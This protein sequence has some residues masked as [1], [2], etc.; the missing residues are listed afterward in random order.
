MAFY[1]IERDGYD[2]LFL[3]LLPRDVLRRAP[4]DKGLEFDDIMKFSQSSKPM[5]DWWPELE[6]TLRANEDIVSPKMPDL[7]IWS[8]GA[9]LVLYPRGYRLLGEW[10]SQFG[11]LLPVKVMN[12][13][14][15]CWIFNCRAKKDVDPEKSSC[16]YVDDMPLH[17]ESIGFTEF[18]D[19]PV[20]FKTDFDNCSFLYCGERFKAAVEEMGLE[21]QS[22]REL[23]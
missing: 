18:E 22:F 11:E 13:S 21:G 6:T 14:D 10:L 15:P 8:G 9:A 1:S 7:S 5:K 2:F 12:Q 16:E 20:I 17:I 4:G 23:S 19:D 3:D